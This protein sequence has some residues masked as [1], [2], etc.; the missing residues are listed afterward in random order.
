M[1]KTV[2]TKDQC[3]RRCC[4]QLCFLT[5]PLFRKRLLHMDA[6]QRESNLPLFPRD[7]HGVAIG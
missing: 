1:P 3:Y 7:G 4:P 6:L 2:T 5:S